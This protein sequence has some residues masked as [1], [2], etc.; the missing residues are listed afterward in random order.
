M[1]KKL[2]FTLLA[3]VL[4]LSAS[5]RVN[6]S[7]FYRVLVSHEARGHI[8]KNYGGGLSV[9]EVTYH[10]EG[11]EY[12]IKVTDN[13]GAVSDF[14]YFPKKN[15]LSDGYFQDCLKVWS[16]LRRAEVL[17]LLH[18]IPVEEVFVSYDFAEYG[19]IA[20]PS[21][22]KIFISVL[23]EEQFERGCSSPVLL[24]EAVLLLQSYPKLLMKLGVFEQ[25]VLWYAAKNH[26]L[27][28][29]VVEKLQYLA[30]REECFSQLLFRTLCEVYRVNKASQTVA[31]ICR[32]LILG[33]WIGTEYFEW[34]ALGVDHEIRVT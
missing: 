7:P 25:S 31:A 24:C 26:V 9:G 14:S 11:K 22:G 30:A 2:A 23:L 32:M 20:Q 6:G 13:D 33:E 5:C 16:L 4:V 12:R 34:Y 28:G 3:L 27:K 19:V 10:G 1:R 21:R 29:E 17:G 15:L 8:E 18:G